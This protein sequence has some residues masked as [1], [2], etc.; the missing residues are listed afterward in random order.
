MERLP[1][2]PCVTRVKFGRKLS[3]KLQQ[4]YMGKFEGNCSPSS[5]IRCVAEAALQAL[6]R[7]YEAAVDTFTLLDV[8][9]V[10]SFDKTQAVLVAITTNHEG[11]TQRL[12]GFCEVTKDVR[13]AVAKAVCSGLNRFLSHAFS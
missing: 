9:T 3:A 2:G 13:T 7:A 1:S 12:V 8:K 6:Q 5:Q 4:S 11:E 10:E